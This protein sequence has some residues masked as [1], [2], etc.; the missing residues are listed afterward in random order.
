M[1]DQARQKFLDEHNSLRS[2]VAKGQAK[3]AIS[4]YAPK[5]KKMKKMIYDCGVERTAMQHAKKCVFAHSHMKGLGENLWMTTARKMDKIKAAEQASRGWFSELDKYGV[6]PENKLTMQ[7]WN[8]PRTQIGHYTQ[9]V[10]QNSYKLGCYVEWC[11]S[12][13]YGVCQYSPQGNMINSLIYEKGN[14]CTKDSDCGS[15]ERCSRN[16]ALCIVRG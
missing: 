13:T 4:G 10:W 15:N 3:D 6:G 2:K 11:P 5:A 7:L 12:M 1:T 16:E 14:P 8:R 9:M